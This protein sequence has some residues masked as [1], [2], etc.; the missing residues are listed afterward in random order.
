M[1]SNTGLGK[2]FL[3]EEII[4]VCHII[5]RLPS[6]AIG[7]KT[8]FENWYGK[9]TVDYDSLHVFGSTTYYH[10]KESKLNPRAKKAIFMG[11]TSGVKGYRLWCPETRKVIFSRDITFD[12]STMMKKDADEDTKVT[13]SALKQSTVALS[14]TEA[15]YMAITEAVKDAIWL[16]GLLKELGIRQETITIFCDSQSVIQLVKNQV[17]HAKMKHIDVRYHFIRE[18]IEE[19]GVT[20]QK[21]KTTKNLVDILT[22]VVN[23]IK[24]GHCLDL[25][26]IVEH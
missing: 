24:F 3:V 15:E 8:P 22:K 1:L 12:E 26:N 18:I 17:Y 5:N 6:A 13:N 2:E 9:S 21:I 11:I 7:G 20:V 25:I 16:Q 4:Y 23:A 10:V 14:T 19:G